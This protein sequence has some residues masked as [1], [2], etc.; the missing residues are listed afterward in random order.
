MCV[1]LHVGFT[2]C[3]LLY[4]G[5]ENAFHASSV[6]SEKVKKKATGSEMWGLLQID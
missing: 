3:V 4:S 2:A 6:T 1:N 5:S